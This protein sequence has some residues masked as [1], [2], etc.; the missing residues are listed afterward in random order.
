MNDVYDAVLI[1]AGF[2]VNMASK[3]LLKEPLG[4]PESV[5]GILKLAVAVGVSIMLVKW[6]QTKKYLPVDPFKSAELYR[7]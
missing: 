6:A 2:G 7:Q 4:T 5:K 1:T 3:K